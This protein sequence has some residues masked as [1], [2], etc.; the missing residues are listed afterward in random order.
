MTDDNTIMVIDLETTGLDGYDEGDKILS[1]AIA[2]V[3]IERKTVAPVFS[4]AIYQELD[5]IERNAWL[6]RNGHMDPSEIE[7]SPF[8]IIKAAE[9]VSTI[10]EG[11]F[12]TSFNTTFDLDAFLYPW[13]YDT[14]SDD[15]SFFY[16]APC[17][18]R[19]A[20]QVGDIPRREFSDGTAWP[21][22]T[23]SYSTLVGDLDG[24]TPHRAEDDAIM[25][26][27][28]LLALYDLGLYD[29]GREEEY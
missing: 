15:G 23:A 27:R 13:W 21:S 24:I 9:I 5:D 2:S 19:A 17:L 14:L 25:A 28:V 18:M 11:Q 12:V 10:L 16:R 20:D 26:G 4:T 1:I 8:G 29:P 3:D 22:L 7:A 6:F